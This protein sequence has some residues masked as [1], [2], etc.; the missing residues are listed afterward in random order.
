M[1]EDS[2]KRQELSRQINTKLHTADISNIEKVATF[3]VAPKK[4][5][6][7]STM[8]LTTET[9]ENKMCLSFD[10]LNDK[11]CLFDQFDS[12]KGRKIID[13]FKQVTSCP[14]N[15]FPSLKLSRDSVGRIEPYTSLF[16]QLSDD[17]ERLMETELGDGRIFFFIIDP[18][19]HVVSIETKHRNID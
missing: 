12:T 9:E 7:V 17:V 4:W 19:F 3:L 18:F 16:S 13:I 5:A 2:K 14:V 6:L 11:E 10:Y 8:P 15:K 1:S